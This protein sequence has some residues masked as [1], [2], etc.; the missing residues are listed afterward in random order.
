MPIN[1]T[2][3]LPIASTPFLSHGSASISAPTPKKHARLS[4]MSKNVIISAVRNAFFLGCV[5][6]VF[7]TKRFCVPIGALII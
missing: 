3:R 7:I 4:D 6:A 1:I 2:I 5:T